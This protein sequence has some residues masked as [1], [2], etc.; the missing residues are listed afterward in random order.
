MGWKEEVVEVVVSTDCVSIS[1]GGSGG[2]GVGTNP[3]VDIMWIPYG[4]S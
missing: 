3:K 4:S 1:P 2:K